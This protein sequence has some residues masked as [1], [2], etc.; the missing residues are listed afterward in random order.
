MSLYDKWDD[1]P[2]K[3][4]NYP[5][6]DSS[7]ACMPMYRVKISQ[8]LCFAHTC[9]RYLDFLAHHKRRVWTLLDQDFQ[10][11]LFS[12][13]LKQFYRSH[14]S[15]LQHNSHSVTQHLQAGVDSQVQWWHIHI[16]LVGTAVTG[17][18][19][20][21]IY[22]FTGVL[23]AFSSFLFFFYFFIFF[24]FIY[25]DWQKKRMLTPFLF[26]Y[27]LYFFKFFYFFQFFI[28][29]FIFSSVFF[30]LSVSLLISFPLSFS[31]LGLFLIWVC[32]LVM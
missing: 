20:L 24:K 32:V 10:H 22:P 30:S 6:L 26:I 3:V 1:F 12:R 17:A 5:H 15:L 8:L 11:G 28:Y 31:P 18:D 29:L 21:S 7:V 23:L 2:F 13:K 9:D 14:R 25:F 27:L 16:L 19:Q 4:Q